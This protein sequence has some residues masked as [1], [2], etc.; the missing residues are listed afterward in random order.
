MTI[1]DDALVP[2]RSWLAEQI[3]SRVVGGDQPELK[4][5][6]VIETPGPRWFDDDAVIKR[7]HADAAM[8]IGG[9]RA[10]L[11]Q[12]L[13]PLAMAGVAQHSDYR[14]D[15]WGRLQRTA[16]FLAATTFGPADMAE[17]AVARVRAVHT[18]V[19]GT[20]G[21]GRRY[22][23]NDPHL[24]RWVHV[25][26]VDSFLTTHRRHG[27]TPLSDADADAY[28]ADTAL[29]AEAL[30]VTHPPR[31]VRELRDEIADFRPELQGTAEARDA[32]RFLI[33]TPP[34]PLPARGPYL[35]L[36]SAAV[37]SLPVWARWPLRLPWFPVSERVL[38]RPLGSATTQVIRWS[39]T[40]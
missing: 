1:V 25:A 11:L 32:A 38:V 3:R 21:D 5:S 29:V 30:G 27:A 23:A 33:V 17:R 15:P 2:V 9:L 18:R 13:H 4:N 10:L 26:E 35:A 16:D 39:L 34:L 7:V 8:F 40:A 19:T 22:A 31:S 14:T 28:V 12:S 20:A 6:A 24:M 36:A 37:A